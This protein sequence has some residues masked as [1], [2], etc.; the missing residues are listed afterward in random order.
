MKKHTIIIIAIA[1]VVVGFSGF[2]S[3]QYYQDRYVGSDYYLR[4]PLDTP[5]EIET[6]YDAA[7]KAVSEGRKYN[8]IAYNEKGETTDVQFSVEAKKPESLLQP[9]SYMHIIK[10]KQIVVKSQ[11]ILE[12]DVPEKVLQYIK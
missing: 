2:K 11:I 7:H 12:K 10:S 8:L 4:V 9:G 6:L 1:F 3:Y 5:T